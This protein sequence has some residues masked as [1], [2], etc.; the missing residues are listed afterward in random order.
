MFINKKRFFVQFACFLLIT[1]LLPITALARGPIDTARESSISIEYPCG[2]IPFRLYRVA[3]VSPGG[4]YTLTEEFKD[5]PIDL[6]AEN[7]SE[8]ATTVAAYITRD[9]VAPLETKKTAFDGSLTFDTKETGLYLI[10]WDRHVTGFYVYTPEP[11]FVSVP[12]TDGNDNWIYDV[13]S[14]PKYTREEEGSIPDSKALRVHKVWDDDRD[15]KKLRPTSVTVQLLCDGKVWDTVVLDRSN[16]WSYEWNSLSTSRTWQIV[17]VNVP[18]A[19]TVTIS[20]EGNTILIVNSL[21]EPPE[22]EPVET[23]PVESEPAESEPAES[24]PVETDP[25]ETEPFESEPEETEPA[26]TEPEETPELPATGVD[27][28]PVTVLAA[29]GLVLFCGGWVIR[30]KSHNED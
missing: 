25:E 7:W 1:L 2:D 5:Y 10:L 30:R 12:S 20:R 11:F 28:W 21:P 8:L 18:E 14:I 9:S 16:G 4:N 24:E 15:A 22:T 23:E 3:T 26:E 19:Y 29:C 6:N 17:E 27:W 13:V